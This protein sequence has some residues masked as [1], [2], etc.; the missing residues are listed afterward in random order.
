MK[1]LVLD[2]ETTITN[3]GHPFTKDNKLMLVGLDGHRVYDIEFGVEPH[4]KALEDIQVAVD[5]C[6]M[7]VGFN[8]KFPV[9][10]FNFI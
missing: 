5:E 7:L 2:V 9:G 10:F 4:K 3:T 6:D 1:T 8:I